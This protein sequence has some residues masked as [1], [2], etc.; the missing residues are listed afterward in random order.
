MAD[1][2]TSNLTIRI[3]LN[4]Y[5]IARIGWNCH[6]M[7]GMVYLA[8]WMYWGY[9]IRCSGIRSGGGG[10]IGGVSCCVLNALAG[11]CARSVYRVAELH[12]CKCGGSFC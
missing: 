10:I 9:A 4:N 8:A 5:N 12:P 7:C 3:K 11:Y 2:P 1:V 6:Q